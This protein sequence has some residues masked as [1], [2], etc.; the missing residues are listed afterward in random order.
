LLRAAQA[1]VK[2]EL[3][4]TIAHFIKLIPCVL[5]DCPGRDSS[6]TEHGVM[7]P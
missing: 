5:R 4:A 6:S 3:T 7:P 1:Y 2:T